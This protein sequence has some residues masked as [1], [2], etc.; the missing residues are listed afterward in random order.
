[1]LVAVVVFF[2]VTLLFGVSKYLFTAL[3]LGVVLALF[4]SYFVAVTVVPLFCAYF[5][6]PVHE[7]GADGAEA[8]KSWG[9]RF[10][11]EFNAK[12]EKMLNFYESVG[13]EKLS[14]ARARSLIGFIGIFLLSFLL[15]SVH[16]SFVFSRAPT[17]ANL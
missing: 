17:P 11:A 15:L 4:A 5:L 8:R 2:P 14:T 9:A 1:M 6:K 13:A 12:F 7:H 3:A 10:H 16:R